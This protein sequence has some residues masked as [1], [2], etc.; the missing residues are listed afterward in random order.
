MASK[1]KLMDKNKNDNQN[2]Y[3]NYKYVL[4]VKIII[5]IFALIVAS[6]ACYFAITFIFIGKPL[7]EMAYFFRGFLLFIC[8]T[9]VGFIAWGL[10]FINSQ[11][12]R[13]DNKGDSLMIIVGFLSIICGIIA[14]IMSYVS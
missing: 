10:V 11:T 4:T 8:L 14:I 9:L 3:K 2:K 12:Y 5:G 6:L 13:G 7:A 1:Q